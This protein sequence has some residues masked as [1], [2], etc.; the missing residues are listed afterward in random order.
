V[1]GFFQSNAAFH[2]L[3]VDRSGNE[4][5]RAIYRQVMNQMRRYRMRS[6]SLRGGLERSTAEHAALLDA[7]ERRDVEE[8]ARLLREHIEVPQRILQAASDEELVPVGGQ[9]AARGG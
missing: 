6:M 2:A 7:M 9:G 8:A 5:L 4:R 3:I 1:D